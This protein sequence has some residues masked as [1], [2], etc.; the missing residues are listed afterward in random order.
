MYF[1][2]KN[3]TRFQNL[4]YTY[5]LNPDELK[6]VSS[7]LKKNEYYIYKPYLD[8]EKNILYSSEKPDVL[9]YEIICHVPLR[10]QDILGTMYSLN[11]SSDLFGDVL[12]VNHHY[13]VYILPIVQNYFE[14]NFL[15]VKNCHIELKNIS[16]STLENYERE[17]EKLE[18]IVSSLRID[19]LLARILHVG[20]ESISDIIKKKKVL[21]NY[22][23]LKD[24]SYKLKEGDVFSIHKI[25]KFQFTGIIK[26]TKSNHFIVEIKKYL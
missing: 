26:N 12:I 25:G 10:H 18:Y 8:S 16:L 17:Y 11:I 9:L 22:E 1:I 20:R 4:G 6:K 15:M 24:S 7:K 3:L 23:I 21:L 14:T 19:I 13:Y 5:F 2:Q